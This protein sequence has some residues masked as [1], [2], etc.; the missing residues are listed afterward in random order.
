LRIMSIPENLKT[1]LISAIINAWRL[2][3]PEKTFSH[4]KKELT[5]LLQSIGAV[6]SAANWAREHNTP[7]IG[8]Q[9]DVAVMFSLPLTTSDLVAEDVSRIHE[10]LCQV[11]DYYA[12]SL[13][14]STA[15]N[16]D[17]LS[18]PKNDTLDPA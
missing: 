15:L 1:E 2:E 17:F 7:T 11:M 14:Y 6:K 5:M 10:L 18:R 4:R 12:I 9:L 3:A 16:G 13:N 8:Q